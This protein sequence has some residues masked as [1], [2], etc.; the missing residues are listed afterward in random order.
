MIM[1]RGQW[2]NGR[3]RL[4]V[5]ATTKLFGKNFKIYNAHLSTPAVP[6][7]HR[8]EQVDSLISHV[9]RHVS[10]DDFCLVGGD[11]NTAVY[12]H[13]KSII[14]RFDDID[15]EHATDGIGETHKSGVSFLNFQLDLMFTN[16]MEI[17]EIGKVED[18]IVSDHYP[19]WV[20]LKLK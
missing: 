11:F 18:S 6:S 3:K 8:L 14:D 12:S 7:A 13:R 9:N 15:F 17:I 4:V 2:F 5:T 20:K 16:K 19:I 1:P 10:S